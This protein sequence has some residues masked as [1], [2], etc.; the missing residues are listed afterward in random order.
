MVGRRHERLGAC[1]R[2]RPHLLTILKQ[3]VFEIFFARVS[4]FHF[5][6]LL[7]LFDFKNSEQKFEPELLTSSHFYSTFFSLRRFFFSFQLQAGN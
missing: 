7:S 5:K 4:Q 6:S 2:R 3:T 1:H